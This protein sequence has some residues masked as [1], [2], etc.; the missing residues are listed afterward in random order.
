M[1]L[2][3]LRYPSPKFPSVDPFPFLISI[4]HLHR[5]L[6]SRFPGLYI[7][8]MAVNRKTTLFVSTPLRLQYILCLSVGSRS[9]RTTRG[10]LKKPSTDLHHPTNAFVI[11]RMHLGVLPSLW[12]EGPTPPS[13]QG[14]LWHQSTASFLIT[15]AID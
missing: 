1:S 5:N 12:I 15:E 11:K 9:W 8:A 3:S 6:S 7:R 13:P 4:S 2:L 14:Y 10:L